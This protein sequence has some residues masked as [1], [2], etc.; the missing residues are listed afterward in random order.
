MARELSAAGYIVR[1]AVRDVDAPKAQ[2]LAKLPNV[3]LVLVNLADIKN[4][5]EVYIG[6]DAVRPSPALEDEQSDNH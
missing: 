3:E 4:L 2:A 1:A 6:T 5:V